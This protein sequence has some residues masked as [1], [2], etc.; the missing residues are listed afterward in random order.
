MNNTNKSSKNKSNSLID[1]DSESEEE[2]KPKSKNKKKLIDPDSRSDSESKHTKNKVKKLNILKKDDPIIETK[3]NESKHT[4]NKVKKLNKGETGE[5]SVVKNLYNLA[6]VNDMHKLIEIFGTDASYGIELLNMQTGNKISTINDIKKAPSMSKSDCLIKFKKTNEIMNI[7]IKCLHGSNPAILNHTPRSA[8]V[9]QKNGELNSHLP[10]LDKFINMINQ[11][12]LK[13][14]VG[15]DILI[16]KIKIQDETKECIID[17]VKYFMF[18]GT[19]SKKS[20]YQCNSILEINDPADIKSYIFV[21]CATY[22]DKKI[23]VNKI[24]ERLVISMRD[25][26]MPAK[27]NKICEP[28]IYISKSNNNIKEKGSLHIRLSK[29]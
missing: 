13:K 11:K 25:K 12:R 27:K 8:N 4:K 22:N 1:L 26:G 19:G 3:I 21:R 5:I 23:Y 28:W 10:I 9:F 14:E 17:T 20:K 15:E 24:Y 7:S 18:D 2:I 16:K 29:K 6:E